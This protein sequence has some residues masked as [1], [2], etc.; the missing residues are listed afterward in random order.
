MINVNFNLNLNNQSTNTPV[1]NISSG[2]PAS[3]ESSHP[4][5]AEIIDC[6]ATP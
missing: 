4:K 1:V 6:N 5:A 2:G 3:A